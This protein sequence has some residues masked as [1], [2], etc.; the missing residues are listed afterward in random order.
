MVPLGMELYT[1][2]TKFSFALDTSV[3][4]CPSLKRCAISVNSLAFVSGGNENT[5]ISEF[6]INGSTSVQAAFTTPS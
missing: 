5:T 3:T 4:T 2:R 6:S 1:A